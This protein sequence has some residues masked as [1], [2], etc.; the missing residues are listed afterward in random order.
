MSYYANPTMLPTPQLGWSQLSLENMYNQWH[1]I[2]SVWDL[3][4]D[5]E[6]RRGIEYSRVGL[7]RT[8]VKYV[9]PIDIFKGGDAVIPDFGFL[10][11]DRMFYGTYNNLGQDSIPKCPVL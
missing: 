11:N 9:T 2:E 4:Q 1:S 10:V 5:A 6:R 7:F 8:D 3:M